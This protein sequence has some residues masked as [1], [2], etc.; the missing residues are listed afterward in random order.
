MADD[1][2]G[3]GI[4]L[5]DSPEVKEAAALALDAVNDCYE[6]P[7]GIH[8]IGNDAA[9]HIIA[10]AIAAGQFKANE[11][12][13]MLRR[14]QVNLKYRLQ[15]HMM[16]A[17]LTEIKGQIVTTKIG[18]GSLSVHIVDARSLPAT[19][20]VPSEPRPDKAAIKLLIKSGDI[21]PEVAR[22]VRGA[23]TIKFS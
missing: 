2:R 11:R 14:K 15:Q 3:E 20:L 17:G 8:L 5:A 7:D 4:E 6:C 1:K 19:C 23:D 16:S 12:A 13:E 21:K 10:L 22:M 18:H 9:E